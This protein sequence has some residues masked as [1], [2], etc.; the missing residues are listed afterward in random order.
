MKSFATNS[1]ILS[2]L[3]REKRKVFL[4]APATAGD[5]VTDNLIAAVQADI[6]QLGFALKGDVV[7]Q[8]HSLDMSALK[9][10][11]A[12]LVAV[13]RAAVGANVQYRPLFKNFPHGVPDSR[14][15]FVRRFIGYVESFLGPF[16]ADYTVLSCGHVVNHRLF[17]LEQFG[18][19]PI[20][21]FQVPELDGVRANVP[22]LDELTP[23][24]L[25]G[26]ATGDDVWA[27]FT[28]VAR[29]RTSLSESSKQFITALVAEHAEEAAR[30]L[31]AEMPFKENAAYVLG[32]LLR[33]GA[34]AELLHR[35]IAT[36]TD[37]LRVAVALCDG[38]VSLKEG[39]RFKLASAHR[40]ALMGAFE[41]LSQKE[42]HLLEEMLGYRGRWL[43]LGEVLHVGKFQRRYPKLH[44]C[45]DVLRNREESIVTHAARVEKLLVHGDLSAPIVRNQLLQSLAQRPGELAR[46]VDTLLARGLPQQEVLEVLAS[47]LS[48]VSTTILLTMLSHFRYRA[49]PAEFRAF[50][51]KGSA[52]KM[53]VLNGDARAPLPMAARLR[54]L[55]MVESELTSRFAERAPLGKVYVS[56]SLDGVL[57]PFSQRSASTGLSP[58]TRGSRILLD[59][60]KGF[61]R[62]FLHWK[63]TD[64]TGTIDV[65]L[66]CGL[67]D[68]HWNQISHLSWTNARSMGR[69]THSGDVRSA[70]GPNGAAEFIDLDKEALLARGVRYAAVTVYSY[71]GQKFSD[72]PCFA[73][74]ME[75]E[76]PSNGSAFDAKTVKHKFEVTGEQTTLAPAVLDLET[77]EVV[78]ADLALKGGRYGSIESSGE[79]TIALFKAV[80]A[81]NQ[82][83][84]G[85]KELF[86]M[87]ACARGELVER[88]EDADI[89]FDE[90]KLFEL[91]DVVANWL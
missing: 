17:N 37:V 49:Q 36:P 33:A 21:Q 20:C 79:R 45:F 44:A 30:R 1:I 13:A 67:Y 19:C 62:L 31:P 89:V 51:P 8:M 4:S 57:V 73:G 42:S 87:H 55:E 59:N 22:P 68:E 5:V 70:G 53:Y 85:L 65:D 71:T 83:R 10:F 32:A 9:A 25:L 60:T 24:K 88:R 26:L 74:F 78:W 46:K 41:A 11:H 3:L 27:V 34:P 38:D 18:A 77:G 12:Q 14:D 39:T 23:L 64:E 90:S 75:R 52:A 50:M 48:S 86:E 56:D 84:V 69:S 40:R 7:A 43:R 63:Q 81:M 35:F 54:V 72:F 66:T 82:Q 2:F 47:V 91:D 76:E 6:G 29:S 61:V 15:Y 80:M 28:N 58:M 16:G